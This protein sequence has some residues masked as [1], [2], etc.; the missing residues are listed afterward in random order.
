MRLVQI[1]IPTG[2][3][4]RILGELDD[5]GIDYAVSDETSNR[6]YTAIVSFPLPTE[7]VEPV[8]DALREAG[9]P[10]DAY[11]V[12]I[13]AETVVSRRFERLKE[14]YETEENGS[15]PR[16]SREELQSR[17]VS[18]I[19]AA[20][21][22]V[23]MVVASAVIATAGVLLDSSA[24]VVG[25]MVIA[26]LIGPAMATSVGTVLQDRELFIQGTQL[27]V[28]GALLA[29]VTATAFAFLVKAIHL[30]P[31]GID[32]FALG[33]VQERLDPDFL[34]LVIALGA[35][36]AGAFSLSTGVSTALVG[37]MIAAALVPPMAVIG[38]GVAWGYPSVVIGASVLLLV[39]FVSINLAALLVLW[40]QGY[41]PLNLFEADVARTTTVKRIAILIVSI[42]ILSLFLGGVTYSSFQSAQ[43]QQ[44]VQSD[45]QAVV[46]EYPELSLIDVQIRNE[47]RT[48]FAGIPFTRQPTGVIV[49]VGRP[50]GQTY[51]DLYADL[52][53]RIDTGTDLA[54]EV[55]F[56][57][58]VRGP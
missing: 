57:D 46:A 3:S 29:V 5:Q 51:P 56:V 4:E 32:V 11:T 19:P 36:M 6:D 24:V 12:I 13:D 25:S 14:Q 39:N 15:A 23:L 27:Q 17:I 26:P 58:R 55:R 21:I 38:I 40:Y 34:S 9:L 47:R 2:M 28:A 10:E 41:Q 48:A 22:Y 42:A 33:E 49:T 7:A 54:I 31:P 18:F 35:G 37:V 43:V 52:S 16:I 20:H 1:T 50:P 30:V 45:V 53:S 8:I 44:E